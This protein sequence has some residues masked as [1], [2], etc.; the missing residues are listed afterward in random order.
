MIKSSNV[1]LKA[2]EKDQHRLKSKLVQLEGK[3]LAA[4][5]REGASMAS[6]QSFSNKQLFPSKSNDRFTGV[7]S[8]GG[9]FK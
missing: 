7:Q 6:L 1:Q 8:V 5:T 9:K 4:M 2:R 3:S